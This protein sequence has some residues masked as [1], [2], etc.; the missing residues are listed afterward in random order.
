MVAPSIR[1]LFWG[2][3]LFEFE[4]SEGVEVLAPTDDLSFPKL[5]DDG[6]RGGASRHIATSGA[7]PRPLYGQPIPVRGSKECGEFHVQVGEHFVPPSDGV[8]D[9]A[10]QDANAAGGSKFAIGAPIVSGPNTVAIVL[11]H[12]DLPL[13]KGELLRREVSSRQFFIHARSDR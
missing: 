7:V 3:Q 2:Q 8:G 11:P 5:D 1:R 4:G 6:V 9:I 10:S 13:D 12:R